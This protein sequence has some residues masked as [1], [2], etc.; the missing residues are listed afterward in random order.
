MLCSI[1]GIVLRLVGILANHYHYFLWGFVS[2]VFASSSLEALRESLRLTSLILICCCVPP[3]LCFLLHFPVR[4]CLI[5]TATAFS[6]YS[7]KCRSCLALKKSW[8][9]MCMYVSVLVGDYQVLKWTNSQASCSFRISILRSAGRMRKGS[10]F[11]F[12]CWDVLLIALLASSL[13]SK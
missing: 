13:T 6:C 12:F 3:T 1:H 10:Y 8:V 11:F 2:T 7:D 4:V 5:S 9:C